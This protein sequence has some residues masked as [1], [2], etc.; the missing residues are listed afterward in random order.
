[1]EQDDHRAGRFT[2]DLVDQG[3][4]VLGAL[5]EADERNIGALSG[6]RRADVL[7]IDLAR[8]HLMPERDDDRSD[9]RQPIL[10][11]IRDK[12]TQVLC[13]A[14]THQGR[15]VKRTEPYC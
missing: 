4:C 6:G 8:D 5:S 11:L 1:M 3:E 12:D 10:A 14:R 9:E 13:F 15:P 7:H 2:N